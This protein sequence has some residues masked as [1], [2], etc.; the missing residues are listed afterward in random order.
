MVA[1]HQRVSGRKPNG[2]DS[3]FMNCMLPLN[4]DYLLGKVLASKF[5]EGLFPN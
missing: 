5:D 1:R 2:H 3:A 4:Q